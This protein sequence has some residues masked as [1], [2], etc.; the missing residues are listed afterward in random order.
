M[1]STQLLAH[2][3]NMTDTC[4]CSLM[5]GRCATHADMMHAIY[6]VWTSGSA[7]AADIIWSYSDGYGEPGFMP[8]QGYDWSGIRDSSTAA[9]EAMYLAI[10]A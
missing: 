2:L 8:S 4:G 10:H 7:T 6:D 5:Q 9:I 1:A 3:P